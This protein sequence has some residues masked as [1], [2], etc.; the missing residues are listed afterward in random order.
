[1]SKLGSATELQPCAQN[2][3]RN[4][5]TNRCRTKTS[6]IAADFP[7]EVVAQSG[8]ATLG[9]WAF[10]EEGMLATG[11][12]G[13]EWRREVSSWIKKLLPFGITRP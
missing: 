8:E 13:W 7:V 6:E 12:A 11:Y 4:P 2:Q 3:E 1:M 10:G 5:D 9:W